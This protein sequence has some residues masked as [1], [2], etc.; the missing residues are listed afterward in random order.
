MLVTLGKPPD[1]AEVP[2]PISGPH[3]EFQDFVMP[4][5]PWGQI[6]KKSIDLYF[7]GSDSNL[8]GN[9]RVGTPITVVFVGGAAVTL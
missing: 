6:C 1:L 5:Q 8:G 4:P 2:I 3:V 9:R 7:V